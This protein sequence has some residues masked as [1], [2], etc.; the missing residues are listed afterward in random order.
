MVLTVAHLCHTPECREHVRAMCQGCH[1]HYDKVHHQASGART[2]EV[3]AGQGALFD[4]PDPRCP[5]V[6]VRQEAGL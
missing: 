4:R 3:A 5:R 6:V 2:R 1:L